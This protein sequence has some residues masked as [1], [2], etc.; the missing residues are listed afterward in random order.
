MY[1]VGGPLKTPAIGLSGLLNR[2]GPNFIGVRAWE[3]G[4]PPSIRLFSR[5]SKEVLWT[6]SAGHHSAVMGLTYPVNRVRCG[7]F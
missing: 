7:Y 4:R 3:T 2:K 6:P 1:W 5:A